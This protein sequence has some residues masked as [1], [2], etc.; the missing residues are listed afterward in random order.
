MTFTLFRVIFYFCALYF[1][2]MGLGL[3]VFPR[4]LVQGAAGVDVHPTILGM[5]R[6]AGGAIIPYSLLY[7]FTAREPL[8]R[9]WGLLVIAVA[10]VL[11]I[12]LDAGSVLMDE[13]K[14]GYAM[15]DI[16]VEVL[17]LI[18]VALAWSRIRKG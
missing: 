6:G 5:L 10:N 14:L 15:M 1:L 12:I 13:Y 4:F 18:G 17:S 3:M 9:K 16:P 7:L 11:A 2:L 8:E